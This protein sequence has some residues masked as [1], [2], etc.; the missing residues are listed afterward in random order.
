MHQRLAITNEHKKA[1]NKIVELSE[2]E[3]KKSW[4]I[5]AT[6]LNKRPSVDTFEALL[7]EFCLDT[8]ELLICVQK[9][10]KIK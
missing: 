6:K 8:E 2:Y 10:L 7:I 3:H 9:A 4:K 1:I 5:K